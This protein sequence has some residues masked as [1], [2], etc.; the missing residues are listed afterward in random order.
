MYKRSYSFTHV[1]CIRALLPT[2]YT[3]VLM[4]QKVWCHAT[5]NHEVRHSRGDLG[6]WGRMNETQSIVYFESMHGTLKFLNDKL[7]DSPPVRLWLCRGCTRSI[8][9]SQIRHSDKTQFPTAECHRT[10]LPLLLC[11][12]SHSLWCVNF[13][14]SSNIFYHLIIWAIFVVDGI[15]VP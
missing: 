1:L 7:E 11:N 2:V 10:C 9:K 14:H 6:E 5:M 12:R 13:A 8:N 15:S 4:T 3:A